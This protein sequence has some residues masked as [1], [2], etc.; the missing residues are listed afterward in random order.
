[1]PTYRQSLLA[2]VV[3]RYPLL[4]G[5]GRLANHNVVQRIAGISAEVAWAPV[6]GGYQ[7]AAPL[8]DLIGRAAFYAGDLDRKITWVCRRLVRPGDRVLDIGAN[9]GLVTMVLAKLVGPTG[10]VEAF[11]PIPKMCDLLQ[12]AIVHNGLRNVRLHRMALGAEAAELPLFVPPGHAGSASFLP[13]RRSPDQEEIVVPVRTLSEI[14]SGARDRVRL[15]KLD[16]E[17]YE[18]QVLDGGAEYFD[19]TPPE[20]VIFELYSEH[21]AEHPTMRFHRD[22]G[23]QVFT[24]PRALVR[25]RLRQFDGAY[26]GHD[27]LA[28]HHDAL[29]EIAPLIT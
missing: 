29:S 24:I 9:L 18:P 1:M 6:H 20:A 27:Y 4:S 15:V 17:G 23:Y 10:H 12:Q 2:A 7:V 8:D 3:R 14:M 19:R 16:V 28:V 22:R 5:C 11:E 26:D 13:E 21:P 25:M